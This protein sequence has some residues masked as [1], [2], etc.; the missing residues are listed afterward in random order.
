MQNNLRKGK[1]PNF[2]KTNQPKHRGKLREWKYYRLKY[3]Y[4]LLEAI[5]G[6]NRRSIRDAMRY[7]GLGNTTEDFVLYLKSL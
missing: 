3:Q 4:E 2:S 6:K 1:F 7:K 5:T